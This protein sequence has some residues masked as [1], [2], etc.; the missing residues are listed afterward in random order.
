MEDKLFGLMEVKVTNIDK[1]IIQFVGTDE[2]KD[3]Q[4]DVLAMEGWDLKNFKKNPVFLWA[5]N[6]VNPPIGRVKRIVKKDNKMYFDVEFADE[7]NLC[8]CRHY[9]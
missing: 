2:T 3:R 5:H 9:F 1:R 4:G 8:I 6:Y 7:K